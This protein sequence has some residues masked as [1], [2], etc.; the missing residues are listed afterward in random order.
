[1]GNGFSPQ[2]VDSFEALCMIYGHLR[3]KMDKKK[4]KLFLDKR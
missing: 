2:S 1:M 3:G 4:T